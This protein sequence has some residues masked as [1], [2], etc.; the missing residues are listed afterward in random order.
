MLPADVSWLPP[1][2]HLQVEKCSLFKTFFL[3]KDL[4]HILISY[5]CGT[6]NKVDD[7]NEKP[8]E[9]LRHWVSRK[10]K[11]CVR[12]RDFAISVKF[13]ILMLNRLCSMKPSAFLRDCHKYKYLIFS[14][15]FHPIIHGPS[16]PDMISQKTFGCEHEQ[17]SKHIQE[18]KNFTSSSGCNFVI[19]IN[20]DSNLQWMM[21]MIT[22][23]QQLCGKPGPQGHRGR[24][25]GWQR[26]S[27]RCDHFDVD[28]DW[29]TSWQCM[30][31]YGHRCQ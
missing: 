31:C 15:T 11:V 3:V 30:G 6:R 13:V 8:K 1:R 24:I 16:L 17:C 28:D 29:L 18:Q 23:H 5:L 2:Q 9:V 12:S 26:K 22:M 4:K 19:D 14:Y 25:G 10:R 20:T 7:K 21:A 27:C